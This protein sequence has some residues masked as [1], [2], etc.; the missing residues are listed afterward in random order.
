MR[1]DA[2]QIWML[3]ATFVVPVLIGASCEEFMKAVAVTASAVFLGNLLYGTLFGGWDGFGSLE[4]RHARERLDRAAVGTPGRGR[5]RVAALVA[6]AQPRTRL[7][8][9]QA[10]QRSRPPFS[11]RSGSAR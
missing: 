7:G 11:A 8:L 1:Y 5:V 2:V 3:T 9:D 10:V 6:A 4:G